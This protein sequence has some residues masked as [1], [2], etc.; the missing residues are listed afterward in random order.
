MAVYS[1]KDGVN[2]ALGLRV[3]GHVTQELKSRCKNP[4]G[5][6]ARVPLGSREKGKTSWFFNEN[7]SHPPVFDNNNNLCYEQLPRK[8]NYSE[9]LG[10][11]SGKS[12]LPM[13]VALRVRSLK[14]NPPPRNPKF[15]A[16]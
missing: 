14:P 10:A 12:C 3:H 1:G 7:P 8:S 16:N 4:S 11:V 9:D 5:G 6:A 15:K 2:T 13:N